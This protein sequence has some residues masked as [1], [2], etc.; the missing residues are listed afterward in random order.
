MRRH[1]KS[2]LFLIW[3]ILFSASSLYAIANSNDQSVPVSKSVSEIIESQTRLT[4]EQCIDIALKNNP[5]I[6]QKKWDTKTAQAEKDIAQGRL[7]PEIG[8]VGGYS[9]YRDDR[10]ITPRRPGGPDALQFTDELVSGDLVLSMPLYT[11]GKIRNEVKATEQMVQSTQ[12][13]LLRNRRELVFNVS[14]I[15]YSMLGQKAVINSLTF[16]QKAL[17]EHRKIV[18]ELLNFQKA[19]RVDLLR[20]EVRLADIEQQLLSERNVLSIQRAL[21]AS[22]LGL[23]REDK[24]F[25]IEG[26]LTEVDFA[27]SIDQRVALAFK[28]RQ[29]YR[30]LKSRVNA[31]KTKLDIAKAERLPEIS[32]RASYGNRWDADSSQDNEVG[33]VGILVTIPLFEGGRIDA[34]VRR[35]H[36]RLRAK[37]EALRELQFQIR[38]ELETSVSNIESTRARINVTQK[39]VEQSKESLRIEREK[40][41]YGKGAI[42]D[43]LD[44]QSAMLES[45]KNYY[46]ALAEYNT[47]LAQFRLA[48][49]EIQ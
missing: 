10:L 24:Y 49:G 45:E 39:A 6:A 3:A 23:D 42:V 14:N 37:K 4:L 15:F 11:G 30:S 48:I 47:A 34:G 40:Y 26:E 20:T 7:W 33:Q 2:I 8:V 36:S 16:S 12:Y 43:V 29:D 19:A 21:L 17:E 31:Q 18:A 41:D 22:L 1:K 27:I 28:N 9:H 25:E 35:E 13:Q 46:R 32:L 44:A 5:G 38:L